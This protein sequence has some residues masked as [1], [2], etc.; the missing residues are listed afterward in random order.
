[1]GFVI[2]ELLLLCFQLYCVWRVFRSERRVPKT[3]NGRGYDVFSD[4]AVTDALP[5]VTEASFG[6]QEKTSLQEGGEFSKH[7]VPHAYC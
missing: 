3:V 4:A 1:M 5:V 7:Q 6:A 2:L